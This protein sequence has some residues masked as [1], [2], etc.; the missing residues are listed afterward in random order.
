M[1]KTFI[2]NKFRSFR[3]FEVRKGSRW[4]VPLLAVL[5]ASCLAPPKKHA[6][7]VSR[8]Q[9]AA[10]TGAS[11][12]P[13]LS[14]NLYARVESNKCSQAVDLL[15]DVSWIPIKRERVASLIPSLPPP[16][17]P[18]LLPYLVRGVAYSATPVRTILR[19]DETSGRLL[20]LQATWDGEIL[21][22]W[23]WKAE[24]NALVVF[25]PCAP[26]AVYPDAWLGGDAI[27]RF[28]DPRV[29]TDSR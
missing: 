14:T 2:S 24:P 15:Q 18:D 5:L 26:T 8:E 20:V 11:H 10:L 23:R 16:A 9:S 4:V 6:W 13:Q 3:L 7:Q 25:L 12:W 27:F 1:L 29:I 21:V 17:S 28:R 22:P 19:F